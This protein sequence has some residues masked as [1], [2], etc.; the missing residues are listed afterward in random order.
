MGKP[1]L[2]R[3]GSTIKLGFKTVND[4]AKTISG[5]AGDEDVSYFKNEETGEEGE[6]G[7]IRPQ[8]VFAEAYTDVLFNGIKAAPYSKEIIRSYKNL[9]DKWL[10]KTGQYKSKA[11]KEFD[12]FLSTLPSISNSE[13]LFVQS[14][15]TAPWKYR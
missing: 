5:Y 8:E 4:A 10:R 14:Y 13:N 7:T 2:I 15:R 1:I 3:L 6:E 11:A 12:S 9:N